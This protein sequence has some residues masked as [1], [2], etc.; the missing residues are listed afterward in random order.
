MDEKRGEIG[1][2]RQLADNTEPNHIQNCMEGVETISFA[3]VVPYRLY[4]V[5][6]RST[7]HPFWVMI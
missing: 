7:P 2:I 1:E 4:D 6:G 5:K 3:R